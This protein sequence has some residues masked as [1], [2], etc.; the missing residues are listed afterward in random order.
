MSL[1]SRALPLSYDIGCQVIKV[2]ELL[3]G[4]SVRIVRVIIQFDQLLRIKRQSLDAT[5]QQALQNGLDAVAQL[6]L[7]VFQLSLVDRDVL[8]F[9]AEDPADATT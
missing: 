5:L 6:G 9:L 8:L 3:A 2:L 4:R 1:G 7:G